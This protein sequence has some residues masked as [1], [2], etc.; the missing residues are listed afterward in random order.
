[1]KGYACSI[2]SSPNN[3]NLMYIY[4]TWSVGNIK[5]LEILKFSKST[6]VGLKCGEKQQVRMSLSRVNIFF[7]KAD[8]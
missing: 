2:L 1:M 6:T 7:L 3:S 8:I 4:S 5:L